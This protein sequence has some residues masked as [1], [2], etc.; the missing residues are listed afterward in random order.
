MLKDAGLTLYAFF[1]MTSAIK[2]V[3]TNNAATA[4]NGV[5]S[6][7]VGVGETEGATVGAV[8]GLGVGVGVAAAGPVTVKVAEAV[9]PLPSVA[10][11]VYVAAAAVVG[12]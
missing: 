5:I 3:A 9:L 12:T 1:L 11:T 7:I 2:H 6:G 4:I 8:V 10:L